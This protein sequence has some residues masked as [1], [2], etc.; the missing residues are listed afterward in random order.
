MRQAHMKASEFLPKCLSKNNSSLC[1]NVHETTI[2]S[3][4]K[5]KLL[6]KKTGVFLMPNTNFSPIALSPNASLSNMQKATNI[7]VIE[8]PRFRRKRKVIPF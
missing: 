8:K 7:W 5:A 1:A 2:K 3:Y 6:Y 4:L